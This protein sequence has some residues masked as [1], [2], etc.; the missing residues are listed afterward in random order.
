MEAL[1]VISKVTQLCQCCAGMLIVLKSNGAI[2][3]SVD[4][5]PLNTSV[6]H[7]AHPIPKVDETLAILSGATIFSIGLMQIV[8]SGKF[9]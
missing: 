9:L 2:R 8:D 1:G 6:F 4:L 5:K 3:I 7:E